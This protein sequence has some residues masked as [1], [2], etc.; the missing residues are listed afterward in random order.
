MSP[1]PDGTVYLSDVPSVYIQDGQ[2]LKNVINDKYVK[3][4]N[5]SFI[6]A[7]LNMAELEAY[8][9]VFEDDKIYFTAEKRWNVTKNDDHIYL[10]NGEP[11]S[12]ERC[13]N[14][15][16]TEPD[17]EDVPV[18]SSAALIEDALNAAAIV[19]GKSTSF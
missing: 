6:E 7:D 1:R 4:F 17:E 16:I 9:Y 5:G 2:K 14:V 10:C 3:V 15:I 8:E 11:A 12:W 13:P 18:D 19:N